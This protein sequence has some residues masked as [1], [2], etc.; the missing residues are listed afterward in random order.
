[1]R[2]GVLQALERTARAANLA[3]LAPPTPPLS[4]SLALSEFTVDA[5]FTP[6]LS[7]YSRILERSQLYPT[8][9]ARVAGGLHWAD[10]RLGGADQ[11]LVERAV[12]SSRG[13]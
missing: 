11:R 3:A 9:G 12:G 2:L 4:R 8:L 5:R 13:R 1:M 10:R 6:E 7:H